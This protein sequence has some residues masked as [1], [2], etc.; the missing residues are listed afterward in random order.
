PSY[1]Q[2]GQWFK[3][4][5]SGVLRKVA[6]AG[7]V[8][9]G[10]WSTYTGAHT[11]L[12]RSGIAKAQGGGPPLAFQTHTQS[13]GNDQWVEATNLTGSRTFGLAIRCSAT[14]INGYGIDYEVD[15]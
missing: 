3:T 4:V 13:L 7:A 15:G 9:G 11:Y 2:A 6:T 8:L 12:K 14:L 10:S 1:V 5:T